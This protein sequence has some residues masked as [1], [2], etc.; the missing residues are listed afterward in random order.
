MIVVRCICGL[1][2]EDEP[3]DTLSALDHRREK[4]YHHML[5]LEEG[6]WVTFPKAVRA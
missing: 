2:F 4:P 1:T 6:V 5:V 3:N